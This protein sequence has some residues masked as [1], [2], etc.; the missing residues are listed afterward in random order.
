[1]WG[2]GSAVGEAGGEAGEAGGEAGK[3]GDEAGEAGGEA[4]ERD[5][6]G[7]RRRRGQGV[8]DGRGGAAVAE[9]EVAAVALNGLRRTGMLVLAG[10]GGRGGV[11]R[12]K[13]WGP[14]G[15]R[16]GRGGKRRHE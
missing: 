4:G 12:G 15:R 11:G 7:R 5:S 8:V 16:M 6:P 14:G 10:E 13:R 1:M 2:P 3:A 9:G